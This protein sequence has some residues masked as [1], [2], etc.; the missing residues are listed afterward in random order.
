MPVNEHMPGMER[1]KD[2]QPL[3]ELSSQLVTILTTEHYNL[4]TG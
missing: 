1:L 2:E 4:Q 3:P